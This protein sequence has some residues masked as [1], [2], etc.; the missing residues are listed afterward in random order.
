MATTTYPGDSNALADEWPY[1]GGEDGILADLDGTAFDITPSG[2]SASV[3]IAPGICRTAGFAVEVDAA[4]DLDL[5]AVGTAPTTGEKRVDVI[6]M[7]Y[8]WSRASVD[9]DT[10][11]ELEVIPGTPV[12]TGVTVEAARPSIPRTVGDRWAVPL[13]WVSWPSGGVVTLYGDER[14]WRGPALVAGEEFAFGD[15]H[16]VGT[17]VTTSDGRILQRRLDPDSGSARWLPDGPGGGRAT[18]AAPGSGLD[19]TQHPADVWATALSYVATHDVGEYLV[20]VEMIASVEG[21]T[22][23]QFA[24]RIN[25]GTGIEGEAAVGVTDYARPVT[26]TYGV[27]H[28]GGTMTINAQVRASG[29]AGRIWQG[30]SISVVRIG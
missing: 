3:N 7:V 25:N 14:P 17:R 28:S 9:L 27:S 19:Y 6:A 29:A 15:D 8:D 12:A 20:I 26:R 30:S 11:G 18:K 2:G 22:E 5:T 13:W 24:C 21:A 23:R 1:I 4:V 16:P 10:A